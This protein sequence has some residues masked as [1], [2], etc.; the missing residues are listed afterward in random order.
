M[1]YLVA[2]IESR[3]SFHHHDTSPLSAQKPYYQHEPKRKKTNKILT[4]WFKSL[5]NCCTGHDVKTR[6]TGWR[7]D[8]LD[9]THKEDLKDNI[10]CLKTNLTETLTD[11]ENEKNKFRELSSL[12]NELQQENENHTIERDN[13]KRLNMIL[14][15]MLSQP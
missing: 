10:I 6:K 1:K 13:L 11:L 9:E 7:W 3:D 5:G 14:Q 4:S 12:F 2:D 8:F 15:E